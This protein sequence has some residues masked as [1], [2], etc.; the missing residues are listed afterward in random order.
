MLRDYKS[1]DFSLTEAVLLLAVSLAAGAGTAWL[2]YDDPKAGFLIGA[3]LFFLAKPRYIRWQVEKQQRSLLLQFRDVLYSVSSSVSVGRS[4]GQALEESM[5]FW[6]DT[7]TEKDL[8]MQELAGMVRRIKEGN[9]RDI[10]VL[11]DF[12]GRSGLRDISDFVMVYEN[13]RDS[14]ADLV[15]AID[16]ATAIIG[17]RI[18]LD[19]EMRTLMVQKQ[20]EGRIIMVSPFALLLFLKISSPG[21]LAPLTASSAGTAVSTAALALVA[22]SILIMERVNRVDF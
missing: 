22:A 2:F 20:F 8:M 1:L 12:A 17:D 18:D 4:M 13:C 21:F 10:D 11:K 9:E 5:D 3:I 15:K 7:Y 6:K 14:G 16:R 19:R